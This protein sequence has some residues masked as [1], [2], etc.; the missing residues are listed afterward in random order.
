MFISSFRRRRRVLG[1]AIAS[2]PLIEKDLAAGRLVCPIAK[3]EADA[4][5]YVLVSEDRAETAAT[6]AFRDWI[7]AATGASFETTAAQSPR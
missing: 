2:K 5:N 6:R 3:P 4:G 7:A 1:I